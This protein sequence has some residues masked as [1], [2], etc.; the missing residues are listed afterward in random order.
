MAESFDR[1]ESSL[2]MTDRSWRKRPAQ[3]A[4]PT[5]HEPQK[6]VRTSTNS[7]SDP[8]SGGNLP[9]G[10]SEKKFP[11]LTGSQGRRIAEQWFDDINEHPKNVPFIDNDPPYYMQK[12]SSSDENIPAK[13]ARPPNRLAPVGPTAPTRSLLAQMD[14]HNDNTD[15]FRSVIDDLTIQNKK[16]KSKLRKYEKLHCSHLEEEKLFEV[17]VHGL[18]ASR[19]RELEET[20]RSFASSITADSPPAKDNIQKQKAAATAPVDISY[21]PSSSST[22]LSK[23]QDSAYASMSGQTGASAVHQPDQPT[24]EGT[25][26]VKRQNVRSFLLDIPENL[27]P[28]PSLAMSDRLKTKLVVKRL[29]QLFTGKG[30]ARKRQDQSH[31]QQEVSQSAAQADRHH[32]EAGGRR[33][34]KEGTREAHILSGDADL[35]VDSMEDVSSG[36]QRSRGSNEGSRPR[37]TLGSQNSSSPRSPEQRPTRPLDLDIHRAQIPSDN[38][39]YI[40]HL[41]LASPTE[42]F[43]EDSALDDEWVYLNLLTGMAQLHTLNVTSDFVRKA[44]S[45][46]SEKFELS[47]DGSKVRWL[48]GSDGTRLS[49]ES[50]DSDGQNL[51]SVP[52]LSASK[53]GSLAEDVSRGDGQGRGVDDP[54]ARPHAGT[55]RRLVNLQEPTSE[56]NKFQYKPLFF[57][58]AD[59]DESENS[60]VISDELSSSEGQDFTTGVNSGSNA[61][62]DRM[63]QLQGR[64][65]DDGPIIFYNRAKFCT[66][67]SGDLSNAQTDPSTYSRLTERPIGCISNESDDDGQSKA[68]ANSPSSR[69]SPSTQASG[70]TTAKY[71]ALDLEDLKSSIS[72]CMSVKG[73]ANTMEASGLG[74]VRPEDNFIFK[75]QVRHAGKKKPA[76]RKLISFSKPKG[77]IRKFLHNVSQ[78]SVDAFRKEAA[79]PTASRGVQSEIVSAVKTSLPPSVLPPPSYVCLPFNS[80]ESDEE[81]EEDQEDSDE[82]AEGDTRSPSDRNDSRLPQQVHQYPPHPRQVGMLRP[83]GHFVSHPLSGS[84]LQSMSSYSKRTTGESDDTSSIDMLAHARVLDP[85]AIAAREREFE[86]QRREATVNSSRP[87]SHLAELRNMPTTDSS[88]TTTITSSHHVLPVPVPVGSS[89]ATAGGGTPLHS[90]PVLGRQPQDRA[91]GESDV[92]SMSVDRN[93]ESSSE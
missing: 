31:Q 70:D 90:S 61:L 92:D 51:S 59:S 20:L 78:E 12:N 69:K 47:P 53:S 84:N 22:S 89:A 91:E 88:N 75:V 2:A 64:R 42:G 27:A 83:P 34:W 35:P 54:S 10:D 29:E 81:E 80:S 40:R 30:A 32:I 46:V 86:R 25:N 5:V 58:A 77:P 36:A 4:I 19:K 23:Q 67:L 65:K 68:S 43:R 48:G 6:R 15:D 63:A 18:A 50:G 52:S 28:K 62:R 7:S 26:H 79:S 74:G 45:E 57:H 49:S 14:A 9:S 60:G 8:T 87:Q 3:I 73:P 93:S 55:K 17:R 66:D 13:L 76:A 11:G 38:I 24:N 33:V 41:G 56:T 39:E 16:L 44:V 71:S 72:D 1:R 21:K 82:V 85:E 37:S